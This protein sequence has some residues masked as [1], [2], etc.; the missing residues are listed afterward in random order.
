MDCKLFAANGTEIPI[1]GSM[2]LGFTVQRMSHFADLL[3]S[4][5]VEEPMLGIDWLTENECTWRFPKRQV[6]MRERWIPLKSRHSLAGVKRVRVAE[7]VCVPVDTQTN[8]PVKLTRHGLRGSKSDWLIES[9]KW[10]QGVFTARTLLPDNSE[11]VAVPVV[12]TSSFPF[13]L[14]SGYLLCDATAVMSPDSEPSRADRVRPGR[15]SA[16]RE[17]PGSAGA[18]AKPDCGDHLQPVRDTLPCDLSFIERR[19]ALGFIDKWAHVFSKGEF[20]VG[21]TNLIPH[22]I[23]TGNHKPFRQPLRRHP[24]VH[25]DFIDAQVDEMLRNDVI[26]PAASPWASN[27][28]LARKSDGSLRFCIDYRQLNELT[29][30]DSYP[31]P[32]ISA[33]LDVLGGAAFYSTMDLRSGFWQTAMDPRDMD[34]TAFFTRRGQ[35]RFKVLSFGLANAPSLFQ[36]IMDLVL[37]GLSWECCL[38]YVDDIIVFARDFQEHMDRLGQVFD[39]LSAAGLKL[40]PSKCRLFQ[41]RVAFLGHIVS[42]EGVEADPSK[43]AA[44]VDWPVPRNVTEVRS[45][46]GLAS[47]YRNFVPNFSMIAAPLF[48][49]TKKGVPFVWDER[50]KKAFGLLKQRLTTAPS[51]LPRETVETTW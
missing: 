25:E 45:F 46:V 35:F 51:W 5:D 11:F 47:Y 19:T 36:R 12:N 39:R 37:A 41:R 16:A 48:D 24:R 22:R 4:D 34:K 17:G 29:Y 2:R 8:V 49:L 28:V 9:K 21:R 6:G 15:A 27:V 30:K 50:C 44:I 38:V 42:R 7:D 43:I 33:C 18:S 26:E 32:R 14:T 20:D 23:N 10:R 1:S 31:L 3:V 40:K 13:R